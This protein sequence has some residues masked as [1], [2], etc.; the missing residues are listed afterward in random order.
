MFRFNSNKARNNISAP[1]CVNANSGASR[2]ITMRDG[3]KFSNVLAMKVMFAVQGEGRGHMTQALAVNEMLQRRGHEVVAVLAGGKP[4]RP[5]P[6]YFEQSFAVPVTRCASPGFEQKKGR[7][8]SLRKS[9]AAAVKNA[10]ELRDSLGTIENTIARA[11][12]DLIVNFSSRCWGCSILFI[13]IA[14]PFFP[15][16]INSC[17]PIPLTSKSTNFAASNSACANT[18]A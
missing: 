8:I 9:L 14:R 2:Q 12:P 3:G 15:S 7:G 6:A 5:L 4:E 11:R 16:D 17:R 10:P 1:R 13:R 18:S